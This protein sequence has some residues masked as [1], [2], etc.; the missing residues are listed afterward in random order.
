MSHQVRGVV[1]LAKGE[2]VTVETVVVPDPGPD[3]VLVRVLTCGFCHNELHYKVGGI[4]DAYPFLLCDVVGCTVT[5][6]E[7]FF[8]VRRDGA[9]SGRH[10]AAI[11]PR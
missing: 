6:P 11:V 9:K 10:L 4:Y 5:E 2:P 1:S 3:E 7:S 8:S